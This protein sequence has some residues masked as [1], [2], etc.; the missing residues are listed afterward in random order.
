M[1][2]DNTSESTKADENIDYESDSYDGYEPTEEEHRQYKDSTYE[3]ISKVAYLIGVPKIV[4]ENE[5]LS[6]KPEVYERIDK[7]KN[8][9]IIRNL[10]ILR[11]Q[12]ERGF[13]SISQKMKFE[14][15]SL[16]SIEEHIPKE[17][18][19][20]LSE[21]GIS[22]R[23]S[24]AQLYQ[25]I[26]DINKLISDRINNCRSLFPLWLNWQY[27]KQ[28]FIMPNG[29]CEAGTKA[30]AAQ[31]YANLN[32]YPY[33]V[34]INWTP[35]EN[36]NILYNDKKFVTLLYEWNKDEFTEFSKVSDAGSY[37]KGAIY[38]Y[39]DDSQK[40][41]F[42]VDCE[43]SDPYKL[44][45]TLRNLD[46]SY[47]QKISSIIL[48]DDVHTASAWRTLEQYTD[49]PVEH[50]MTERIKENKSLV[51]VKLTART[52]HEHYVNHVDA[53]VIVSSDSD[54]WGLIESLPNAKFLVMI[55][56][57]S[58]G[59]DLKH[60]LVNAG[61]F[62]CYI[63]DFYSGNAEDVKHGAI[64]K[65]MDEHIAENVKLNVF[66]MFNEALRTTRVEMTDSE[67]RQF[68]EKYV[69]TI[70]MSIDQSGELRLEFKRRR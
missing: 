59:P 49:I 50:V 5:N 4:F 17:S 6:P 16:Y 31:F 9:R 18:V 29:L 35:R 15:R 47:T 61:I 1:S 44:S 21:D 20:Q 60:A 54:F 7:D 55:E 45:A 56:R 19:R 46:S 24:N 53:F 38:D 11:T 37:V 39:I 40:V 36:G 67:K 3:I 64:F 42:V 25:Y 63:D 65:A 14:Y 8:A 23:H 22:L 34:Y 27:L 48:F 32:L 33:K 58:C 51:D 57:D 13:K 62:Y 10:C 52:C 12:I 2:D 69:K 41:V 66:T 68:I 30:A 28:I 70:Q 26:I 43:N